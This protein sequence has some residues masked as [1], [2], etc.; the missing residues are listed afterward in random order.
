VILR[1]CLL[2][3]PLLCYYLIFSLRYI[4][5]FSPLLLR[6]D[7]SPANYILSITCCFSFLELMGPP[8]LFFFF[9]RFESSWDPEYSLSWFIMWSIAFI[10]SSYEIDKGCPSSGSRSSVTLVLIFCGGCCSFTIWLLISFWTAITSWGSMF[11]LPRFE[12]WI[13]GP[14]L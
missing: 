9:F 13:Y 2:E 7:V 10:S 14:A 1:E 11:S 5:R 4:F 6:F 8:F 12:F 3:P